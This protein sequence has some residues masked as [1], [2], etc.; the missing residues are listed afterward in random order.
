MYYIFSDS[1]NPVF[2]LAVDEILLKKSSGEFLIVGINSP[3][4]V[5]G[6][7]QCV[8]R[9]TDTKFISESNIPLIRRI[10]GGG[11]VYHDQGNLNFSFILNSEKGKQIDFARYTRPVIDFL[12]DTGLNAVLH[13]SDIRVNGIKISGNAE[14]VYHNRVLHHG[15]ILFNASLENLRN[16]IRKDTS[17]YT[18]RAVPSNPAHVGNLSEMTDRFSSID[19]LGTAMIEYL[20][21]S[22]P[23]ASFYSLNTEEKT[24]AEALAASKYMKWEWNYAYGPEYQLIKE[25]SIEGRLIKIVI[26]VTGGM[27]EKCEA[28]GDDKYRQAFRKLAGCRHMPADIRVLMRND[29]IEIDIFEFF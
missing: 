15:T 2:N 16:C 11:T 22:D 14:H 1:H 21:K 23:V 4:V 6:K 25:I 27:I 12:R 20:M 5:A 19:E 26:S 10:S 24:G 3:V 29:G 28:E 13:G 8:H 18:T 17:S 7:H 9:E